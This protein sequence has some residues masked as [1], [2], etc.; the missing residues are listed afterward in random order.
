MH[1]RAIVLRSSA[2]LLLATTVGFGCAGAAGGSASEQQRIAALSASDVG[3]C[4]PAPIAVPSGVNGEVL[5]GM[6]VAAR[7]AVMECL[8]S[9]Q[10]RGAADETSVS[11]KTTAGG[12]K[13]SHAVSG[14]NLTPAGEQCI[15]AALDRHFAA[16]EGFAEAASA[17]NPP[18]TGDAQVNHVKGVSPSVV[19]GENEASDI[20]GAV[21]LAQS[22]WCDC[23]TEWKAGAPHPLKA[24]LQTQ[25]TELKATFEAVS[26]PA[27]QKVV[28]CLTEKV[29]QVKVTPKSAQL[30]VPY[31][32]MFVHSGHAAQLTDEPPQVQI[33]QLDG[34]RTQRAAR[35]VI[36]LGGRT[37]AAMAYDALGKKYN[38]DPASVSVE[39]LT[40]GCDALL[41]ADD[42]WL[43]SLNQQLEIDQQTLA[44]VQQLKATDSAW[45]RAEAASKNGVETTKQDI[46]SAKQ[47]KVGDAGACPRPA[48]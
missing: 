33:R 36:A 11:L 9:P 8:V 3:L 4:F 19:L 13:V 1:T 18:V 28:A 26:D 32:F 23:Y 24:T 14:Q 31:T 38:A 6:L 29:K 15:R 21:R 30:S 7:P 41:A 45:E 35:A 22:G 47:M 40:K 17:V 20:T 12:G 39:D 10:S 25:G 46:E 37:A 42:A 34:L 27:S 16:A 2:A 44:L 5:T 48:Q 43:A